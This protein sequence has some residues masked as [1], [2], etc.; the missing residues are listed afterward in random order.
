M[1][2]AR[3]A[4]D[5]RTF[6]RRSSSS[7]PLTGGVLGRGLDRGRLAVEPQHW[8]PAELCGADGEHARAGAEIDERAERLTA[9]GELEQEAQTELRR[10]VRPGAERL[11]G[12]DADSQRAYPGH[13]LRFA[14][15]GAGVGR[16]DRLPRRKHHNAAVADRDRPVEVAPAVGPVVGDL[17]RA[18]LDQAVASRSLEVRQL[19]TSP[20]GP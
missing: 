3:G 16:R 7:T 12:V 14:S 18:D 13:L 17:G 20:G 8:R 1:V 5:S 2:G 19:G 11:A 15:G 6:S 9:I 4:G 10:G